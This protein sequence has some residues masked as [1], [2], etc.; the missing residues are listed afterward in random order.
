MPD[1]LA[2]DAVVAL[3]GAFI[4]FVI[5]GGALV[6]RRAHWALV[7]LPAVAWVAWLELTGATCPL[8]PLEN[9]LRQRAGERGY[10][11]GFVEHYLLP[12]IYPPGLTPGVQTVLGVA[13]IVLNVAV[14]ALAWR[15]HRRRRAVR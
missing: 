11:G 14:Y 5:L 6:M 1:R 15:R 7:H 3:H 12:V 10:A 8:T 2:A 9:V 4:A 13:V